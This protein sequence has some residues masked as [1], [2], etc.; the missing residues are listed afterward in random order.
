MSQPTLTLYRRHSFLKRASGWS[1]RDFSHYYEHNHGPLA[2]GLHGFRKFAT[3]YIQNHVDDLPDGADP[4]FDGVTMTTQVPRDDYSRGFREEPDF[5][6]VKADEQYL[7]DLN[8]TVSVLGREDTVPDGKFL[9]YKA[10]ILY[11]KQALPSVQ[12]MRPAKLVLNHLDPSTAGGFASDAG[13]FDYDFLAEAWFESIVARDNAFVASRSLRNM[14][15]PT[16]FLPVRE[17]IIFGPE[18]PWI[19]D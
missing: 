7:F 19:G 14:T 16:V 10:L 13:A 15:V 8:K 12:L 3:R 9:P 6:T 17:V 4:L 11:T 5:D 1:R 2:A 18:K